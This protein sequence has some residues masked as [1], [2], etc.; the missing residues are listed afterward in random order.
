MVI[1]HDDE[2]AE[3]IELDNMNNYYGRYAANYTLN[4]DEE[5]LEGQGKY[6]LKDYSA[7]KTRMKF[8]EE[9]NNEDQQ[10]I[11][12]EIDSDEEDDDVEEE[13]DEDIYEYT[14]VNGMEDKY[15]AIK[16]KFE[17]E[18]YTPFESIGDEIYIDAFVSLEFEENPFLFE[19]RKYPAFFNSKHHLNHVSII[20]IP[21]GYALQS[22]PENLV[23]NMINNKGKF[24]YLLTVSDKSVVVNALFKINDDIFTPEEYASLHEFFNQII[25]K[26]KEKIVFAKKNG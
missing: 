12:K 24:S 2:H 20:E 3:I 18:L 16:G 25:L 26:Q 23:L 7:V 15:G 21:E 11:V 14:E 4:V 22:G 13:E 8:K 6:V 17:S 5:K 19:Q 10:D 1:L 9:D